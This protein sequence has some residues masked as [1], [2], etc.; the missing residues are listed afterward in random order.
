MICSVPVLKFDLA[1][2]VN[3]KQNPI[4]EM[5]CKSKYGIVNF[6]PYLT[7]GVVTE[8]SN[9]C[10]G[11]SR[12]WTGGKASWYCYCNRW[13]GSYF[14]SCFSKSCK[15]WASYMLWCPPADIGDIKFVVYITMEVFMLKPYLL[16][17]L[18]T[19]L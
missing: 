9:H 11:S 1:S 15:E 2:S 7:V 19:D 16:K 17:L 14:S 5:A 12:L 4:N 8:N 6:S 13:S 3:C 10:V 18:L